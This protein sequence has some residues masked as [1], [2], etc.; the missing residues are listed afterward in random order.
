MNLAVSLSKS[1]A[2]ANS[3]VAAGRLL[4]PYF[5]SGRSVDAQALRSAMQEAFGASDSD[6]AW[7]WKDGYEAAE[8]AQ[9]L[10]LLK[11]GDAMRRQ[12]GD[13]HTFLA[14]AERLAQL[15]LSHTR[16]S[17]ESQDL[18]QFST[19]LS[20]AFVGA[21]AA[22]I[23]PSDLVLEPSAGTGLFAS[24]ARIAGAGLALNEYADTRAE[25]LTSLFE[26]CV[27][28]R[29]DAASIDDRLDRS[30]EPSVVLINPPFSAAPNVK[31]RS[32]N[33][34]AQHVRSSLARLAD[35][36]RMVLISGSGF[37][38]DTPQWRGFF[39]EL[40][41]RAR[42]VF[43]AAID[44]R[45]YVRH[46]TTTETRLTVIDKTPADETS[47]FAG[48]HV[49][50]ETTGL[51]LDLVLDHCPP[52]AAAACA[53]VSSSASP[54]ISAL[55]D[56][57][58]AKVRAAAAERERHPLDKTEPVA[59]SYL[60]RIW[61]E[62]TTALTAS[63]YEPYE[64][65]A[66]EIPEAKTHP[67]TLVQSAAM[68]SVAPSVPTHRPK[69][70][71][72]LISDGILSDAQL[73]TII[74]AGEAHSQKLKGRLTTDETFDRLQLA[75]DDAEGS[76]QLRR[77]F[78]LGDG[79]GCGKGRQ[80][81]GIIMDNWFAGRRR[82]VWL[83]KSDKLIEDATR[84]WT[85][86]G[87]QASD[88]VPLARF[89]QGSDITLNEGILF[90]T[91]ATLRS[92]ERQGKAGRLSQVL[93]WLGTDFDGV[94][95][96]DES[97]A[98][99]NAAGS[100]GQRGDAKPSQ[101]GLAGLR[102]QHAVPDARVLYVSATG[103]TVVANLAYAVRLGLW[104]TGEF[105]F[106]TRADFI[107]SMEAG[108]IGAMEVISRDLKAL[109]LYIAR[110]ISFEGVEY[111]MLIHSLTG[112]QRE[113]YDDYATAYQIIHKHL[114]NA[115]EASGVT[116]ED[117]T[118][119]AQAK[120]AARSAFESS[121]QR[122]FGHLLTSMKCP[123]LIGSIEA[124][125]EAGNAV[126]VQIVS[127]SEALLERRLAEIPPSEWHDLQV[128][129]TPREYVLDYLSHSFPT[130]LFEPYTDEDGNLHSRPA[131]DEFGNAIE[132]REAAAARD[133]L[134]EHLCALPAVPGA[135]DQI[136]WHFGKDVVAEVTGRSR[137][138]VRTCDNRVK[139][140]N[141]PGSSNLGEAQAFMDDKKQILVFSDA[142]GT[143]RSYHADLGARN[144]RLRVHY[145]LEPGWR[146]DN[147]IQGLGR[148]HRTN[149]K[150]PPLFRPVATDVKGEKRFLS[151]IAR[152]LDTLGAITKGQ[153]QTGGQ[154]MFRSED[155]L[156]SEYG[157]A[158]LRRFFIDIVGGRAKCCSLDTFVEL[159][160]LSLL[161]SDGT[162]RE[163]LPP[164]SRFLNRVLALSIDM[165]NR[166]FDCF[167]EIL[168]GLVEDAV[169][170]GTYDVGLETLQAE[171]FAITNRKVIFEHPETGAETVALTIERTDR[172]R[173]VELESVRDVVAGCPD[174]C[175]MINRKSRRAAVCIPTTSL[176]EE[177]GT[178]HR[179]FRLQRPMATEKLLEVQLEASNWE[180][181][182]DAMFECA[183]EA[184]FKAVP[185]FTTSTFT[186]ISG[187]LLPIWSH[188]PTDNM[189][190]YRLQADEGE[191]VIG[192]LVTQE[193]LIRLCGALGVDSNIEMSAAD[194]RRAVMDRAATIHLAG[195]LSL[196]RSRVMS[197]NRLEVTG[198][199][200][201]GL[202]AL[203]AL[204]CFTEII[205]WKTRAFIPVGTD[206]IMERLLRDHRV[207]TVPEAA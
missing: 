123:S 129:V 101:Q 40:Q 30:I 55:R 7:S 157:R 29:H 115:L 152:R 187:L 47:S 171:K 134:I 60:P 160:G 167:T 88:I 95:A 102:L 172:N 91:Y 190:V 200:P 139:L 98:M 100:K 24:F 82:A 198:F 22:S 25:I 76:F 188:L 81:A 168:D 110:S 128:D 114:E 13:P 161:D 124:D 79:T 121:K 50:A 179:R 90:V 169:A 56:K 80:V 2:F 204:G 34:T 113:I 126:V 92:A 62:G 142:G 111:D 147:A 78:M 205:S 186:I 99:A 194:V 31:G 4:L 112:G 148:T 144:Q 184:E 32:M 67:T 203:K 27:I 156:E 201:T 141:R 108:G 53:P 162:L 18:Q 202:P 137:R 3:I 11:H 37:A 199:G 206:E 106:K 35:N 127:T 175:L 75:A 107:A 140:E 44:G 136:V 178:I 181:V 182:A 196:R 177:D 120:S 23:C 207:V 87:G 65:Q 153:R 28:T 94:I 85:A 133:G 164:I 41:G 61:S 195:G 21:Q 59:V 69:L 191:R 17:E 146:A 197:A 151:T 159:T 135:L 166:I 38:P 173:P 6:G 143:G 132:C 165:Q 68:A 138:I 103:A 116:S 66:I 83:S 174:A 105:P 72:L 104:Q 71:A 119:N 154:G 145:L 42:V 57:A 118:L 19:P 33:A 170:A 131:R 15:V 20:L 5:Q 97:H 58:V 122:F 36:G 109:G 49:K 117:R 130:Q 70:P 16:R 89:K 52:R 14:M 45:V 158:A 26:G 39:E 189:R 77:G 125:L 149:Q 86:L 73:E 43:S 192:R 1:S 193:Q 74:Y 180:V 10:F 150:Q 64:V 48:L 63:L 155:N 183:W 8:C 46:G 51:L 84:D 93:D 185:E 176:T 96:F 54:R 163:Q 12:A 9:I